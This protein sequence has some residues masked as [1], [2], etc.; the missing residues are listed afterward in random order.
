MANVRIGISI[1]EDLKVRIAEQATKE[2]MVPTSFVASVI[3][4]Y[5]RRY[6]KN[7]E[8]NNAGKTK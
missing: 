7:K 4:K 2:T 5:I 3:K 8:K 1:P 6:L